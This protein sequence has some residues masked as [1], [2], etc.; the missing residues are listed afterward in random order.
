MPVEMV[1]MSNGSG[2]MPP[3][4]DDE[5][6][7]DIISSQRMLLQE[8]ERL[9][10]SS[11]SRYLKCA[12]GYASAL[13]LDPSGTN[14]RES[15]TWARKAWDGSRDLLGEEHP[16]TLDHL[17]LLTR[18]LGA[19]MVS[20]DEISECLRLCR[21]LVDGLERQNGKDDKKTL[22]AVDYLALKLELN[23]DYAEAIPL[24]RRIFEA[25]AGDDEMLRSARF[26]LVRNHLCLGN[27]EAV[28]SLRSEGVALL[29]KMGANEESATAEADL[30]RY[31]ANPERATLCVRMIDLVIALTRSERNTSNCPQGLDRSADLISRQF[32]RAGL[33]VEHQKFGAN[34]VLCSNIEAVSPEFSERSQPHY[35]L[36]AHYDSAI[37]TEGADDNASAVAVLLEVARLLA[38]HPAAR[39]VRFVAFTN[40][41][42]P[43]FLND[44]MGSRVYSRLC[45]E[46]GDA[47]CGM[48][49][50]E[51]LGYFPEEPGSRELLSPL[52]SLPPTALR[53]MQD[54]QVDPA[55][56]NFLA[57]IGNSDSASLLEKFDRALNLPPEIPVVPLEMP[58]IRPSDHISFWDEG[59]PAV[60]LTAFLP[61]PHHHQSTDTFD[62]LDY[63]RLAD[64]S[65][66]IA[67]ALIRLGEHLDQRLT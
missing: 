8:A 12:A 67:Q 5:S 3:A 28:R 56:G 25:S 51:S 1:T 23:L 55:N 13:F 65:S 44:S 26:F 22:R 57:L 36:G 39:H 16:Q 20:P 49:C 21:S 32:E 34:G 42:P 46:R 64:Q 4:G 18:V 43:H 33:R 58:G 48:I 31:L 14:I 60:M 50:M 29:K 7:A 40:A 15:L 30:V 2:G 66:S 37:G 35:I 52:E 10:G 24:R 63:G 47:I 17:R 53:R 41:E 45:R 61:N 54:R 62:T 27:H 38:G 6:P 59:F 19:T 11:S 9:T